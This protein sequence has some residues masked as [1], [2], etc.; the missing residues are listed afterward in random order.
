MTSSTLDIVLTNLHPYYTYIIS[1][2][3]YTITAGPFSDPVSVTT[4]QDSKIHIYTNYPIFL[5]VVPS[6]SP[7][8][9]GTTFKSSSEVTL[10]WS[11]PPISERNGIL[12]G[13]NITIEDTT[14]DTTILNVLSQSTTV[15]VG[16]LE[17]YTTYQ[18]SIAA[19][20]IIGLGPYST[21]IFFRTLEAGICL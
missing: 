5:S 9:I 6:S 15:T 18:C 2:A 3:A 14:S 7:V 17:P 13:Y 4:V 1:V 11:P 12:I 19:Y 20:T 16:S 21:L 10:E 8:S